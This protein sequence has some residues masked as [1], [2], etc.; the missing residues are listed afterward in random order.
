MLI[1]QLN[2]EKFLEKINRKVSSKW[3]KRENIGL[4]L[5]TTIDQL[6][7]QKILFSV[8]EIYEW[9]NP[10]KVVISFQFLFESKKNGT[11]I[12]AGIFED[13]QTDQTEALARDAVVM[14]M[15]LMYPIKKIFKK[16]QRQNLCNMMRG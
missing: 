14:M 11:R 3:K 6:K 5:N 4:F 13:V 1:S 2:P 12:L 15:I 10:S 9:T 16:N 8:T 7:I